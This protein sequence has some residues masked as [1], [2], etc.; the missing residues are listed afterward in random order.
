MNTSSHALI[1]DTETTG[2]KDPHA[3]EI[4]W[5]EIDNL[6]MPTGQHFNARFNPQK[7]IEYGASKVTGIYDEDVAECPPH[8][9][10]VMPQTTYLI[11][12]HISYDLSVLK[13]AGVDISNIK[14]IC[15]CILARKFF[16]E[17]PKFSL[18]ALLT[19][20]YPDDRQTYKMHAHGAY[21]DVLFTHK[22]LMALNE[23]IKADDFETLFLNCLPKTMP[24]GK[25]KGKE[26]KDISP[27]YK[28]W[29]ARQDIGI[30]LKTAL[31][32]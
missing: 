27:D 4:A 26:F 7:P 2:T 24:F 19:H 29:L 28:R 21:F 25:H 15:T 5:L 14:P 20:F 18:G 8:T 3:T 9:S 11:G 1:L 16:D 13:N 31:E 12:H 10:F 6:L 30:A 22:V 23:R 17:L 32:C